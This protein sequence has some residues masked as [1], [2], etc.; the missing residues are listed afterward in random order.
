MVS[1]SWI[2]GGDVYP[3]PPR[4]ATT[5][6]PT[7][8]PTRNGQLF[9]ISGYDIHNASKSKFKLYLLGRWYG[10]GASR[11]RQVVNKENY[12]MRREVGSMIFGKSGRFNCIPELLRVVFGQ[13][14]GR[15]FSKAHC[16]GT[17]L[18]VRYIHCCTA[19]LQ[20]AARQFWV[21]I[22]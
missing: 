4:S 13:N 6:Y 14:N 5:R 16:G 1:T 21:S 10:H 20:T 11:Q 3:A 22:C 19:R 17:R 18:S 8:L 9:A 2:K 7:A 12:K 15:F